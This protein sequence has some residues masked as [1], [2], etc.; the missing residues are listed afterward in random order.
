MKVTIYS[1]SE[2]GMGVRRC[3]AKLED[4]RV[5]KY[6]QYERGITATFIPKGKRKARQLTQAY[7]PNMVILEGWG[8]PEPDSM[9]L[10]EEPSNVNPEDVMVARGRYSACDSRWQ[11]DFNGKLAAH[12]ERTGAKVL[13]DF[14]GHQPGCRDMV[15]SCPCQGCSATA[16]L[17]GFPKKET[18]A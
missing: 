17:F 3:E 4:V 5:H 14:R 10:P 18:A 1:Q 7:G 13:Y 16:P 12:V 15:S 2:F 8:H 11:S 6:A 9:F